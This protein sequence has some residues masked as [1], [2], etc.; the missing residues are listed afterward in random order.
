MSRINGETSMIPTLQ[1]LPPDDDMSDHAP[2]NG[3]NEGEEIYID[4][5][6][7][8]EDDDDDEEEPEGCYDNRLRYIKT[9]I[10]TNGRNFLYR[11]SS[12]P[13][14]LTIQADISSPTAANQLHHQSVDSSLNYS[15]YPTVSTQ[16]AYTVSISYPRTD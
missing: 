2:H 1:T 16:G 10:N 5:D 14:D 4:E 12:S 8:D 15:S 13:R 11:N 9:L 3:L 7:E 6:E